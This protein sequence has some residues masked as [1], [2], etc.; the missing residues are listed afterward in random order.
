MDLGLCPPSLISMDHGQQAFAV[1]KRPLEPEPAP[2]FDRPFP[3]DWDPFEQYAPATAF[4]SGREDRWVYTADAP[5]GASVVVKSFMADALLGTSLGVAVADEVDVNTALAGVA[6][7]TPLLAVFDAGGRTHLGVLQAVVRQIGPALVHMHEAGVVHCDLKDT[8]IV[9]QPCPHHGLRFRLVDLG[10]CT[11]QGEPLREYTPSYVA[12]EVA[13][14]A[15]AAA[16]AGGDAGGARAA[17]AAALGPGYDCRALGQVVAELALRDRF[18]RP[19]AA[20]AGAAA[21]G[22]A[23][24]SASACGFADLLAHAAAVAAEPHPWRG[25]PAWTELSPEQRRLI[26]ALGDADPGH[27]ATMAEALAMPFV[28]MDIGCGQGAWSLEAVWAGQHEGGQ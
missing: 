16:A 10:A 18:F 9:A 25:H 22:S 5:G 4:G 11:A 12:P 27:R 20:A 28:T 6:G 24:A 23:D 3:T 7:V 8:N 14:A 26:D 15:A 1:L 19:A 21:S 17:A 13:A 2:E